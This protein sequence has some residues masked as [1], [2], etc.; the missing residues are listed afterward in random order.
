MKIAFIIPT[1][2][3]EDVIRWS[4]GWLQAWA[5]LKYGSKNYEIFLSENGSTDATVRH[6]AELAEEN[7]NVFLIAS[8]TPGKGLALKRAAAVADADLYVMMDADLSTDLES[9]E[10]LINEVENGVEVAIASRRMP[11][12]KVKRPLHR[13]LITVTYSKLA[14]SQLGIN[15]NDVQCGCKVLSRRAVN[16]VMLQVEDN[17][18]FFDTELLARIR[19]KGMQIKEVPVNWDERGSSQGGSKVNLVKTSIKFL[20]KLRKLKREIRMQ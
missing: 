19:K 15:V 8:E 6:T 10:Q 14:N 20:L 2:N 18:F 5:N 13:K 3:E 11:G 16:E 1:H 17:E 12:S 4:V 7:E 9:V